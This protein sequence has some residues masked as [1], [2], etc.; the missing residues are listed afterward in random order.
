MCKNQIVNQIIDFFILELQNTPQENIQQLQNII[1]QVTIIIGGDF[2]NNNQKEQNK[3]QNEIQLSQQ[4]HVIQRIL[5]QQRI[6]TTALN[7]FNQKINNLQSENNQIL[8]NQQENSL[9]YQQLINSNQ[10]YQNQNQINGI[11]EQQN[12]Q[13]QLIN[14]LKIGI[15]AIFLGVPL[16]IVRIH[17]LQNF[18]I[19]IES[20]QQFLKFDFEQLNYLLLILGNFLGEI[21]DQSENDEASVSEIQNQFLNYLGKVIQILIECC[22]SKRWTVRGAA[23]QALIILKGFSNDVLYPYKL[24][25]LKAIKNRLDDNKRDVRQ[26]AIKCRKAWDL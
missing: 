17:I 10:E 21:V 12:N 24:Q 8:K 15:G 6:F 7:L 1:Q 3:Q 4:I 26:A 20:I 13:N 23:L 2:Q 18:N 22:G 14:N 25:V 16:G 9:Q 19:F 5:W 11:M